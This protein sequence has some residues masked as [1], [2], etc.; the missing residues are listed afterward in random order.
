MVMA[1]GSLYRGAPGLELRLRESLYGEVQYIMGNGHMGPPW[2][3]RQTH[4][5]GNITFPKLRWLAVTMVSSLNHVNFVG[6]P[7]CR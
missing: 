7:C 3:D 5:T 1:K 4:A 6:Y 2:K